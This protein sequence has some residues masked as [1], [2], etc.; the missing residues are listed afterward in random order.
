MVGVTFAVAR[1]LRGAVDHLQ[2]GVGHLLDL[3]GVAAGGPLAARYVDVDAWRSNAYIGDRLQAWSAA[4]AGPTLMFVGGIVSALV[5]TLLVVFT[6]FYFF[7][8]AR[9]AAR[10]RSTTSCRSN[11]SS[12]TTS[13]SAR[14]R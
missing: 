2:G 3:P 8:D 10:A 9:A 5:Q 7:R 12:P 4:I 6:M 1:E 14:A 11:T 13:S